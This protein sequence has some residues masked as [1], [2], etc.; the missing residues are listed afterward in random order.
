MLLQHALAGVIAVFTSTIHKWIANL[1]FYKVESFQVKN[2]PK[3]VVIWSIALC[4][5]SSIAQRYFQ[6]LVV[7]LQLNSGWSAATTTRRK[8]HANRVACEI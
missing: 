2:R 3:M 1:H 6:S 8:G 7:L 5:Y 4:N